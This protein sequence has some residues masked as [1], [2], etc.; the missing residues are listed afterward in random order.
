MFLSLCKERHCS[1]PQLWGEQA[2]ACSEALL[3][4]EKQENFL[5]GDRQRSHSVSGLSAEKLLSELSKCQVIK[6]PMCKAA[7]Q[8][9]RSWATTVPSNH[10]LM[11]ARVHP[12]TAVPF[13]TVTTQLSA[14]GLSVCLSN[15]MGSWLARPQCSVL[16]SPNTNQMFV[17]N[18]LQLHFPETHTCLAVR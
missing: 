2:Q 18:F 11:N 9:L 5:S 12:L 14:W 1:G 16:S 13:P 10:P 3:S 4:L 6:C 17:L 8:P 15:Q 7:P